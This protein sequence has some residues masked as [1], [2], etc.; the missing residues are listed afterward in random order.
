MKI[1]VCVKYVPVVSRIG[2]DYENKTI[3]REGVPSEI[4]PFDVLALVKALEL[5]DQC[6]CEVVAVSMGPP[7]AKEG[8]IQCLA[9][10]ADKAILL[11]DRIFAGS[12]TLATSRALSLVMERESPDLIMCGRNSADAETGQVGP[13]LAEILGFPHVSQVRSL[14]FNSNNNVIHVERVTDEGYQEIE[15]PLPAIACV[16]EGI[17]PERFAKR[18]DI[19][20][21]EET[22]IE[23]VNCASLDAESSMFGMEGS[24]TWVEDIRLVE[25]NRSAEVISDMTPEQF[26]VFVRDKIFEFIKN[27]PNTS[28]S[29]PN[30]VIERYSNPSN[31]CLLYTS[32]SP[33]D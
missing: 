27:T 16:T 2:F 8:L 12:D 20:S 25:P 11:S 4:N 21:I 14:D 23:E 5:K 10:G 15:C 31:S 26:G 9:L 30:N 33:R 32:P 7:Q 18:E 24:P 22:S 1:A 17:A 3:I 28:E 13:E 19:E 29:G 6:N